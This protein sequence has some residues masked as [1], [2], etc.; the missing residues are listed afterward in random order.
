MRLETV[1]RVLENMS[2]LFQARKFWNRFDFITV[3]VVKI[4]GTSRDQIDS[5][6]H[7]RALGPFIFLAFD[8]CIYIYNIPEFGP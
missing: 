2:N 1:L 4:C 5:L 6:T 8:M 7:T 3:Q